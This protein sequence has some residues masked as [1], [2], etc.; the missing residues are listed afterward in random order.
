M[1]SALMQR[2]VRARPFNDAERDGRNNGEVTAK[3]LATPS[4][5][6]AEI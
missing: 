2:L 1:S 5:A 6:E 3:G 4:D